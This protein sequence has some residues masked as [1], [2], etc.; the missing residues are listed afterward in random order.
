[1]GACQSE[2]ESGSASKFRDLRKE[3]RMGGP[4]GAIHSVDVGD[5][6]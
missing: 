3:K 5:C 6:I 1:M 2:L 4:A